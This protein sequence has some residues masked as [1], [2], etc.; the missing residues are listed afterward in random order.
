MAA[1]TAKTFYILLG[2]VQK[3]MCK[4][5]ITTLKL[6]IELA[7]IKKKKERERSQLRDYE[8]TIFWA[9]SLFRRL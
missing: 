6:S 1:F 4:T 9:V 8:E 7:A 3:I 2:I 5:S